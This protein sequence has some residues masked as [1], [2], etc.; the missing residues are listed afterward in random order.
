MF[1]KRTILLLL[2]FILIMMQTFVYGK[3]ESVI[4]LPGHELGDQTFS[5]TVGLFIPLFF[6]DF[7]GEYLSANSTLGTAGHLQWSAYINSSVRLGLEFGGALSF[8]P[9]MKIYLMMPIA[10]KASYIFNVSRFE[11]PINLAI[12]VNILKYGDDRTNTV[13]LVKPG[14]S[15]YW[16]FD[17]N[18]SFGI[19]CAW[20]WNLEFPVGEDPAIM[21]NF[22]TISPSLFYHF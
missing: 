18:F 10:A 13:F 4:A 3:E 5:L 14:A 9:N 7:T 11:F 1:K 19:D 12:G 2:V 21:A 22:L 8:D 6:Q 17:A 15:V 20:W 16:R